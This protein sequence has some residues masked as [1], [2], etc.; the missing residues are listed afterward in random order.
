MN[1]TDD[2]DNDKYEK[3]KN[4]LKKVI[5]HLLILNFIF[6]IG[7]KISNRELNFSPFSPETKRIIVGDGKIAKIGII[8]DFQLDRNHTYKNNK[9]YADN[10][11]NALNYFKKHNIDIIIIAGDITN[12]GKIINYLYFK[13]I[14]YSVYHTNE[15]PILISLMGNHDFKDINL[16]KLENQKKF[17]KYMKSYPYSHYLINNYNFIFWS[18]NKKGFCWLFNRRKSYLFVFLLLVLSSR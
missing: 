11:Y 6:F 15:K 13:K 14:F 7:F 2:N 16:S 5:K 3:R 9:F 4:Y 17:F 18:N 10:L 12:N 8:S 1:D